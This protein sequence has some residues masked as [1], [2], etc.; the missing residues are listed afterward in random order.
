MVLRQSAMRKVR[1]RRAQYFLDHYLDRIREL[2]EPQELWPWGSRAYGRPS[3]LSD[4]DLVV[5]SRKF[6]RIRF[7]K[8]RSTFLRT[9]RIIH[10]RRLEGVDPLYYTPREFHRWKREIN[11]VS[12][13]LSKAVRII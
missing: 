13:A 9:L 3:G 4:I 2:F 12:A 11:I 5:V 10:D 8:R 7:L 1:D 6:S